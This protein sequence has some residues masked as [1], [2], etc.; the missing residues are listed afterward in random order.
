MVD[1]DVFS[2]SIN[3]AKW[4]IYMVALADCTFYIFSYLTKEKNLKVNDSKEF[5]LNI[6]DKEKENGLSEEIY[7]KAKEIF[8]KRYEKVDFNKY[9]L[10]DPFKESCF[11]LYHWSPVADE[12]KTLDKK[13]VL[14]S[15]SLKW[16]LITDEFKNLTKK[17]YF[18]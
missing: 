6:I 3:I 1:D 9:Y 2:K 15:M 8:L 17:L 18:S 10:E 16:N 13:I 14:N 4:N 5:F 11:A 7:D 12:L